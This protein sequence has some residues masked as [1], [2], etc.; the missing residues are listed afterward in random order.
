MLTTLLLSFLIAFTP[1]TAISFEPVAA[2]PDTTRYYLIDNEKI[3]ASEFNGSQ[4]VGQKVIAY[5]V[6]TV[7]TVTVNEDLSIQPG[8]D[9]VIILHN[10]RTEK[11]LKLPD[12]LG[13]HI[14][15]LQKVEPLYIVDGVVIPAAEVKK[16]DM[17]TIES[18]SVL[19][20]KNAVPQYGQ[21]AIY[22]AVIIQT[23]KSSK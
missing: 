12:N 9:R 13:N 18:M 4:L 15:N 10:I 16:M 21:A 20:A 6:D 14:V 3:D 8:G 1:S 17:Q 22:G 5:T 11:G 7:K 19:Q 23:K 2:A